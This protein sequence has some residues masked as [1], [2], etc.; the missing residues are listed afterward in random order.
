M[1]IRAALKTAAF[2][3]AIGATFAFA[4]NVPVFGYRD[5]GIFG[6]DGLA[7]FWCGASAAIAWLLRPG[8]DLGEALKRWKS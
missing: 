6:L 1:Q 2:V 5:A 3:A 8:M 4:V 7:A